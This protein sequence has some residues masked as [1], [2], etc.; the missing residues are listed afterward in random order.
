MN[1]PRRAEDVGAIT[2][3]GE[4]AKVHAERTGFIGNRRGDERPGLL[5]GCRGGIGDEL[6]FR[7]SAF[8]RLL[9]TEDGGGGGFGIREAQLLNAQAH[10][11]PG[12]QT[13][14]GNQPA[15][16]AV[17][18]RGIDLLLFLI[19]RREERPAPLPRLR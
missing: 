6:H 16:H 19:L 1:L 14:A 8:E 13:D 15:Q 10:F 4:Y 2:A 12:H 11:L 3:F 7:R 18:E 17:P 9:R 5:G